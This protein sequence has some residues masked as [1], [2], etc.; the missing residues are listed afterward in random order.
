MLPE[1]STVNNEWGYSMCLLSDV[2][3]LELLGA[4]KW[5]PTIKKRKVHIKEQNFFANACIRNE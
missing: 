1:K 2:K 3:E 5:L 4:H